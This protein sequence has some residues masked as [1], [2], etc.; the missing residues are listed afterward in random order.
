MG[1]IPKKAGRQARAKKFKVQDPFYRGPVAVDTKHNRPPKHDE[2][3]IDRMPSFGRAVDAFAGVDPASGASSTP[4]PLSK[5][6][7]KRK[8]KQAEARMKAT[9]EWISGKVPTTS[10]GQPG[11]DTELQ[12]QPLPRRESGE[13]EKAFKKRLQQHLDRRQKEARARRRTDHKREKLRA[14]EKAKREA[15][16]KK[17][18][19]K[20]QQLGSAAKPAFG[21]VVE[22]PPTISAQMLKS[23]EKLKQSQEVD[24]TR[25]PPIAKVTKD[26]SRPHNEMSDYASKVRDAYAAMKKRR[27]GDAGL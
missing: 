1:K 17:K 7:E 12:L 22:R 6:A 13:S 20:Q 9:E 11:T 21:D 4:A 23:R 15:R 24:Q 25:G 16:M 3:V 14:Q 19:A 27:Y 10:E 26:K 2:D 8:R 18:D 5:K